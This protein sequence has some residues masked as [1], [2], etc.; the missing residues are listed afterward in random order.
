MAMTSLISEISMLDPLPTLQR[1]LA[2][3][4]EELTLLPSR[5]EAAITLG[6]TIEE[7]AQGAV[8]VFTELTRNA[9]RSITSAAE[10]LAGAIHR[11]RLVHV[12]P[13]QIQFFER[14]GDVSYP[15]PLG[16]PDT[17]S[18]VTFVVVGERFARPTWAP[19]AVPSPPAPLAAAA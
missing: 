1:A 9:G 8:V 5:R 3:D 11:G 13:E 17:V 18:R 15:H 4:F 7:T 6:V 12:A 19:V 16:Q 14:Y 10:Y 2:A